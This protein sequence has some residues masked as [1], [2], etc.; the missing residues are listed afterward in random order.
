MVVWSVFLTFKI[1]YLLNIVI[2]GVFLWSK[3]RCVREAASYFH[4]TV[5]STIYRF[6]K[7]H[8]FTIN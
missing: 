4:I 7:R 5:F 3:I 1:K 6:H 2:P 8:G